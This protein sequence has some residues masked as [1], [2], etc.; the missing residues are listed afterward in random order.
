MRIVAN[1][2][3]TL[4]LIG[5]SLA[6]GGCTLLDQF[7]QKPVHYGRFEATVAEKE[8]TAPLDKTME[9][10]KFLLQQ[11]EFVIQR[12]ERKGE[13]AQ[14]IA[15]KQ[16]RTYIFDVSGYESG[17]VVHLEIDQ[18]GNDQ[19]AWAV[20]TQLEMMPTGL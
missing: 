19:R 3:A 15:R 14:L 4:M 20:M 13:K 17:T 10:L 7:Y 6:T 5:L 18:A 8:L 1:A 16:G 2:R 9:N 12:D 11:D